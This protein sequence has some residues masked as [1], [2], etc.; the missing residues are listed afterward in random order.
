[1][2][3]I[4]QFLVSG[5]VFMWLIVLCSFLAVA[6]IVFKMADLRRES[7]MPEA[8]IEVLGHPEASSAHLRQAMASGDSI[9]ARIA[10]TALAGR[11][12]SKDEA[13]RAVQASAREEVIGMERGIAILEVVIT[14]APLLGLLGTVSG[15]VSVFGLLGASGGENPDPTR[16]ALGISEALNTTIAGLAVAIPTVIA[17]SFF[18][19]KVERMA[20]RMEV[21]ANQLL[22][23]LFPERSGSPK[24]VAPAHSPLS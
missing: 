17:H 7:I 6:V 16:L 19:K 22:S 10:R 2:S 14:I 23:S 15:L 20:A 24:R 3:I 1:M 8:L 5:G 11:F 21:V 13:A 18:T 4:W 12:A 9:L